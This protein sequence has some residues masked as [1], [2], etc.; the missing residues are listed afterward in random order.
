MV[1]V[2]VNVM[3]RKTF[4]HIKQEYVLPELKRKNLDGRRVYRDNDGNQYESVTNV[5]GFKDKEALQ[6]WRDKVGEDVANHISGKAMQLGTKMHN[7]IELY[8]N[9]EP[10]IENNIFANA[11][12]NNIQSLVDKID[13]I[14]GVEQ[15][16][17]SKTLGLAG[18]A[19][20]LADYNGIKSIIDFKTSG[21]QKKEE[22]IDKYFMQTT[23]YS[24]M[25]E[26]LT[27]ES[28]QQIVV[29]IS[30][31][32]G[33]LDEFIRDRDDYVESLHEV[34]NLYKQGGYS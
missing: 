22:W 11:H 33:S 20:C 9:N 5:V 10:L 21:K 32:D 30:G 13:N 15:R 25:W 34:I 12:F 27:G 2:G 3:F 29:L 1:D 14:I 8:L 19:D 17:C 16:L 26:E 23:A 18:T 7:T 4:K 24:L 6:Q 31:E 28:L